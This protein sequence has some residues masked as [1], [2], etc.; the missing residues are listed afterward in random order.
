MS[1]YLENAKRIL[2]SI[3][4]IE[5]AQSA[6][7]SIDASFG[8]REKKALLSS[9]TIKN[10]IILLTPFIAYYKVNQVIKLLKELEGELKQQDSSSGFKKYI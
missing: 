4:S 3:K 7:A 5:E 8:G 6:A 2:K 9:S 1:I 10:I